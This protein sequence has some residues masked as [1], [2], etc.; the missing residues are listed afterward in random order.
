MKKVTKYCVVRF[1]KPTK[2]VIGAYDHSNFH[3]YSQ[4]SGNKKAIEKYAEELKQKQSYQS[5][6]YQWKV[7]TEEIAMKKQHEYL[8]W[9]R[10]NEKKLFEK[11]WP[12]RYIGKTAHEELFEM[13]TRH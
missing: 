4:M 8:N 5:S 9:C 11:K 10:Q 12:S 7:M 13:M 6:C 2:N 1:Y 3:I